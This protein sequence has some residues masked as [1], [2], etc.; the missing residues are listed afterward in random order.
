MKRIKIVHFIRQL[1]VI[2]IGRGG[3]TAYD[4]ATYVGCSPATIHNHALKLCASG[5]LDY[6]EVLHR[7]KTKKS[8]AIY[9]R[10]YKLTPLGETFAKTTARAFMESCQDSLEGWT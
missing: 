6:D 4:L 5:V 10:V 7:K 2:N 8:P 3:A 9:K 1:T